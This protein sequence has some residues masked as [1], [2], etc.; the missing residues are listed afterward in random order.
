MKASPLP[1]AES[2]ADRHARLGD[3]L[4]LGKP[5][6]ST[7]VLISTAL[8]F[9]LGGNGPFPWG[10]FGWLMLGTG[11]VAWGINAVNQY[12]ER[13]IDALMKRTRNRPL[14]MGRLSPLPVLVGG[15]AGTAAGLA[16]LALT[17]SLLAFLIALTV[18]VLYVAVYTPLKRVTALN[19]LIGAVPGALPAPLG[20]AA[21]RGSVGV[22]AL[23]LF[24]IMFIWQL[25]HFLPIAWLYR[26][27]YR[28]AGLSMITVNDPSGGS[29]RRQQLLYTAT[30]VLISLHPTLIGMA[31]MTYF[32]GALALG[33]VFFAAAVMMTFQLTDE[34]AR[35]VL[36]VSVIYLPLLL[37]L[38]V[39]DATPL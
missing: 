26:N 12:M 32:V 23:S 21:A 16:V 34:R 17:I 20:W 30:L 24:L 13:D 36:R 27:D 2:A 18:A 25:P 39:Y 7:M 10:R 31:G 11:L 5:R 14:P 37:G 35:M 19:T 33:L 22:E 8:G 28:N 29:T 3:W 4:Q 6:I 1:G 38:L 9:A 15:L